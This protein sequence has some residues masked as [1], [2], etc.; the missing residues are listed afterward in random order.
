VQTQKG[1]IS[2]GKSPCIKTRQVNAKATVQSLLVLEVY[3]LASQ[4]RLYVVNGYLLKSGI[5]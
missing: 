1:E 2:D 3:I 5:E 4:G